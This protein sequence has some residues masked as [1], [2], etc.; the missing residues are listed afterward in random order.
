M[1]AAPSDPAAVLALRTCLM[2]PMKRAWIAVWAKKLWLHC[3]AAEL[4]NSLLVVGQERPARL[5][6]WTTCCA[7]LTR[8][9]GRPR[10]RRRVT[11]ACATCWQTWVRVLLLCV[12]LV[13]ARQGGPPLVGA[14]WLP[15]GVRCWRRRPR[16]VIRHAGILPIHCMCHL[17]LG[18]TVRLLTHDVWHACR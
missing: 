6:I 2:M 14:L 9:C 11:C 4:V 18:R 10:Q 15:Q 16:G 8:T 17:L 12:C 5:S 1:L 3:N 7:A 13:A